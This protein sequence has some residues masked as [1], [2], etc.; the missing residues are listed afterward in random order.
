MPVDI[1]YP[2]SSDLVGPTFRAGGDYETA[3]K[4]TMPAGSKVV[5]KVTHPSSTPPLSEQAQGLDGAPASGDWEVEHVLPPG[6]NLVDCTITA[7]L[8]VGPTS[9]G[10]DEVEHLDVR[11]RAATT[12]FTVTP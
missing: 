4:S 9:D 2:T 6:T 1:E 3:L 5:S 7:E 12:L 11:V 8:F 10:T